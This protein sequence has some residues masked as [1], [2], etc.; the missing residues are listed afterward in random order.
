MGAES[1][2]TLGDGD[3][4][5][6]VIGEEGG[7][8]AYQPL[9]LEPRLVLGVVVF[10]PLVVPVDAVVQGVVRRHTSTAKSDRIPLLSSRL[11]S[12]D[13]S[14]VGSKRRAIPVGKVN[15]R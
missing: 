2:H 10:L 15:K 6:G 12:S 4:G 7:H 3:G 5:R 13:D 11:F 9:I 1:D 14:L 8:A